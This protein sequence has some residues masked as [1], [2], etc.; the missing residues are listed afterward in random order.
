MTNTIYR[1]ATL[2]AICSRVIVAFKF[3]RSDCYTHPVVTSC[4]AHDKYSGVIW[5]LYVNDR[6][7]RFPCTNVR[8]P[9]LRVR[10]S[11]HELPTIAAH[12]VPSLTVNQG[13]IRVRAIV[14]VSNKF[15]RASSSSRESRRVIR[16]IDFPG[17]HRM[18]GS[19]KI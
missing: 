8:L 13:S 2:S 1:E 10:A 15:R 12:T 17:M 14:K 9:Y 4:L 16:K 6:N 5:H 3:R 19:V 7:A 18:S 11:K